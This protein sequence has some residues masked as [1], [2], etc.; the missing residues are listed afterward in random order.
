MQYSYNNPMHKDPSG[1]APEKEKGG[2]KLQEVLYW[3]FQHAPTTDRWAMELLSQYNKNHT[4]NSKLLFGIEIS[5]E[6]AVLLTIGDA[7][8]TRLGIESE[9][10]LNGLLFSLNDEQK[11][12][13][14]SHVQVS[15]CEDVQ[16]AS[17]ITNNFW[18]AFWE[19]NSKMTNDEYQYYTQNNFNVDIRS[20]EDFKKY[21]EGLGNGK[22]LGW[23]RT[24]ENGIFITFGEGIFEDGFNWNTGRTDYAGEPYNKGYT[25]YHMNLPSVIQHELGHGYG[26]WKNGGAYNSWNTMF[27]ENWAIYY[28][29]WSYREPNGI[30]N[31]SYEH[32]WGLNIGIFDWLFKGRNP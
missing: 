5:K 29:N 17:K 27:K 2:N 13:V 10:G 26:Y 6:W 15:V 4:M 28:T 30:H 3:W 11:G 23:A 1:L 31:Q 16:N 20:D 19:A 32:A 22:A 25:L 18:D 7:I 14:M 12:E 8:S 9:I 21:S 24:N